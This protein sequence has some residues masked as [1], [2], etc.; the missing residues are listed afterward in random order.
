MIAQREVMVLENLYKLNELK[1]DITVFRTRQR[2]Y[3]R[4]VKEDQQ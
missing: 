3:T 2:I 4:K 1:R